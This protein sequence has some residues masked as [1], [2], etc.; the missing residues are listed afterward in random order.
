MIA[1]HDFKDR[2]VAVFGLGRSG[3][4]AA[5]ALRAGQ[6][7]VVAWDDD[8][9]GRAKAAAAGFAVTDPLAADWRET[10]ALVLS[11]GVP[12]THPEPHPVV[13]KARAA[14]AE[15]IGDVELFIRATPDR[16]KTAVSGTNGKSTTTALIGHIL[17][18]S[19]RA[20]EIGGNLGNPVLDLAPLGADGDYVIELSSYQIDL[21]PSLSADIAVLLNISPDHLDRHGGLAGYVAV[22]RR[23]FIGQDPG[24]VA[25][26]GVDDDHCRRIHDE[27]RARGRERLLAVSVLRQLDDGVHVRHGQLI[28]AID[29]GGRPVLDL[30]EL[31][32][33]PGRHN[34]QNAACAY[35]ACRALG[36][37][38]A[39]I[40]T[41]LRSFAGLP[42]RMERLAEIDGVLFVNDSKATNTAATARALACYEAIY[43]IAGGRA[44]VGGI[45]ELSPYFERIRHAFLIGEAAD[46]MADTLQGRVPCSITGELARAVAAA[47]DQARAEARSGAVVLLSPAC[48]SFDQ[49]A[50]FEARGEAFR[51][52]VQDLSGGVR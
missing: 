3:L 46:D 18:A 27:L 33:L 23:L 40:V 13:A 30:A 2:E 4:A 24:D 31:I 28:D 6:A 26:I 39:E 15:V 19:G 1:V 36:L 14:G 32:D 20:T 11:P 25:V 22:K 49:F 35:A 50:D 12:L 43:W 17:K 51:A 37:A 34:W 10:A 8:P 41:G 5:R 21:T 44:K 38:V 48:P 45:T 16:R 9:A 7:R 47:H 52:A 29:G 42:H